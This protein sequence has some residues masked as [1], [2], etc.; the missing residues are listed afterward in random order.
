[1]LLQGTF[2]GSIS[3]LKPF[4]LA[5]APTVA[6]IHCIYIIPV[7]PG[8]NISPARRIT[9][10]GTKR[11]S[12]SYHGNSVC[13]FRLHTSQSARQCN[14][15]PV[16]RMTTAEASL[17]PGAAFIQ[18]TLRYPCSLRRCS[19]PPARRV[20]VS[21]PSADFGDETDHSLSRRLDNSPTIL[22]PRKGNYRI[23]WCAYCKEV[24]EVL[25]AYPLLSLKVATPGSTYI[26]SHLTHFLQMQQDRHKVSKSA[27]LLILHSRMQLSLH[28]DLPE[29]SR[30]VSFVASNT[31]LVDENPGCSIPSL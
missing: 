18:H 30:R 4:H 19:T 1:M 14:N 8:C 17:T 9:I 23:T 3:V 25:T 15:T 29:T 20:R 12:R 6:A 5:L 7:S 31:C 26:N 11:A 13:T 24:H 22:T 16:R 27:M 10:F 2:H 28:A 21:V